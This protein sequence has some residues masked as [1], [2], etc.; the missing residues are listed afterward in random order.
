MTLNA[1]IDGRLFQGL[2]TGLGKKNFFGERAI[3]FEY[4]KEQ[5]YGTS[6]LSHE[7]IRE[8]ELTPP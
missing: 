1:D 8:L 5:V 3:T 4:L 7:G 6:Q 2:L